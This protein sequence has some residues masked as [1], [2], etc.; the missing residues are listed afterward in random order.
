MATQVKTET[1]APSLFEQAART[2]L[3]TLVAE[4]PD[5]LSDLRLKAMSRFETLG[6]PTR[7]LEAWKVINLRPLAGMVLTHE[8]P[9]PKVCPAALQSHL[10]GAS[11]RDV[12]RLVFVNGRLDQ[13][14]SSL[15]NPADGILVGSLKVALATHPDLVQ[16][17]LGHFITEENDAFA[18]L[19]LALFEDGAFVYVPDNSALKPLLQLV[20]VSFGE[21]SHTNNIRNLIVLGQNAQASLVVEHLGLSEAYAVH[22]SV[23]EFILA[24]GAKAEA[25][26]VL[27]EGPHGWHLAATRSDVAQSAELNVSTMTLGGHVN[28]HTI[29]TLIKGEHAK[30]HLN[31]LDVLDKQTE[32]YHHTVTEHWTGNAVSDQ[33]Y[34]AILDDSSKSEF[35]SLVFVANDADGTDSHQLNQSLLLSENARVWTRPQ[36]QINADDVKCAHGSAVG[37]LDETQLFYLA[38]RGLDRALA[39]SLLTYGFA[40]DVI[41]RINNPL[42]REYLNAR[43]LGN[44]HSSD[45]QFKQQLGAFKS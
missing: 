2:R 20:F 24:E 33:H 44:L 16:K 4:S 26:V 8:A 17:H 27:S 7:K 21:D 23:N 25:T 11:E 6:F 9:E 22:N 3:Q 42:V 31:G 29:Q 40:E 30:V 14:R 5:W 43:V 34:K 13:T 36:L 37:Q 38:S 10:L 28:R 15:L 39:Q 19:N 45:D 35:N 1:T 18:A 41:N 32:I 12:I